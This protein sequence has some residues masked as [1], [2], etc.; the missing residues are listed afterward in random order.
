MQMIIPTVTTQGG[1]TRASSAS[2]FD[3]TG[4]LQTV[5]NDVIRVGYNPLSLTDPPAAVVE[6]AA[7]NILLNSAAVA[8][9]GITVAAS[10][11]T[12]SFYGTGTITLSGVYSSALVGLGAGYTRTSLTFLPTAGTLTLTVS[13]TCSLG[14]LELGAT[15][16]SYIATTGA[17]AARAADVLVNGLVY[18][19]IPE[20][21]YTAWSS[22]TTYQ[23]DV[24]GNYSVVYSHR[25][26][27]SLRTSNTNHNPLTDTSSPPYWLDIGPTNEYAMFDGAVGTQTSSA[28]SNITVVVKNGTI[29]GLSLMEMDADTVKVTLTDGNVIVYSQTLD[30]SSGPVVDWWNY[31]NTPIIRTT[32]FVL[33]DVPSF[34]SGVLT[35][36]ITSSSGTVKCGNLVIGALAE[37][38]ETLASPTVGII[39]Y[40]VK[41]IDAFGNPVLTK[42][43]YSKRMSAKLILD[44]TSVDSLIKQLANVRA[45]PCVWIGAA[46]IYTSLIIY[47][48]YKD[49]EVDIAYPNKS[50][51]TLQIEGLI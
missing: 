17:S 1:F 46:N 16:T 44:S 8:T 11:Y 42:R 10:Q 7:T 5:G 48:Y 15:A 18:S 49:F 35:V 21:D 26:Y 40:S 33:T 29:N 36:V 3:S 25:K 38:G 31:F 6:S 22:G 12:L 28:S 20:T 13:G 23:V 9:Q 30:L 32:D 43:A 24:A 50:Y 4:T 2:Y 27:A 34:L 19:N 14:Q 41:T 51:C 45:T 37:L 39:D 47:G